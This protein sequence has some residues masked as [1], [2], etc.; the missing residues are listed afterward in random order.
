M[1]EEVNI[2]LIIPNPSN[3]RI[4]KDTKFAKLVKSIKDFPEMLA[5]R[6]I[7]V[8]E[9]MIVLGGNMRLKA[10]IEAGLKRVPIIKAS[11]LTA[12]QQKEFIIK[13]NVGYGE[14]D[15]D[16]LAN[17]WDEHLL[18]DWGLDVPVFEP[19]LEPEPEESPLDLFLVELTFNDEES[20]QK[21]Y[22]ELI[23]KGYN[24]RL[25]K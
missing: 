18:N 5:L 22:T 12:D 1:I 14:W 23:E 21:A 7:V 10:C 9:Y 13:D 25:S 4:I 11:M 3:P 16:I 19:T 17:Q 15:W 20:R 8:D 2:K 6:P 24:V